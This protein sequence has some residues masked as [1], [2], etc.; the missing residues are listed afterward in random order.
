MRPSKTR[1][2]IAGGA[3]GA[4]AIGGGVAYAAT[5]TSTT[6]DAGK[7]SAQSPAGP[8]II[9]KDFGSGMSAQANLDLSKAKV[10]P[11]PEP[12]STAQ[13]SG[14]QAE[15]A[16]TQS[17]NLDGA[18]PENTPDSLS[19]KGTVT[20]A[21]SSARLWTRHGKAPARTIG[22]LLATDDRET[23]YSCTATVITSHNKSTVWTAG[24]CVHKGRGGKNG[25]Y[26]YYA[27]QPDFDRGK[28]LGVWYLSGI[29]VMAPWANSSDLRYDFAAFTVT[30]HGKTPI[31]SVT[32]A[33]GLSFGYKHRKYP[34]YTFG[35][36]AELLPSGKRL[37]N[38]PDQLYYCSGTSFASKYPAGGLGIMCSMGPGASGGPWLYGMKSN[39]IGRVAGINSTHMTKTLQMNSPYLGSAAIKLYK[40]IQG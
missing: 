24:H 39:G 34:F 4:L 22:R 40:A 26:R 19:A 11:M 38:P 36:P 15:A 35:Y 2:L 14:I 29:R 3:A 17:L 31:Q 27:F 30:K 28:G 32:G 20:A 13:S 21:S 37:H 8:G 18:L 6:H 7:V 33:Q 5:G 10:V 9:A 25:F 1:L 12:A 23:F 16:D